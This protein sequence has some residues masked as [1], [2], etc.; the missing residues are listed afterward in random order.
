MVNDFTPNIIVSIAGQPKSGKSHLA[1]TFPDPIK[2]FSLDI[3]LAPVLAKFKDKEIDVLQLPIPLIDTSKPSDYARPLWTQF[4]NEYEAA[5]EDGYYKTIVVDT[6]TA[7]YEIARNSYKEE[8]GV[9]SLVP[10]QY[11]EVY[12]RMSGVVMRAIL[13]GVNLVLTSY[14]RDRYVNDKNTGEPEL[15][16]WKKTE[17]L[18]DLVLWT[19]YEKRTTAGKDRKVIVTSIKGNRYDVQLNDLE[20]E[21]TDYEELMNLLMG[22]E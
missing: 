11:G 18:V 19:A 14:L 16:G 15:D 4:Q 2:V 5:I 21:N 22:E 1:L 12:A 3:G 8:L 10:W 20:L 7:L 17:S 9:S 13:G 6:F